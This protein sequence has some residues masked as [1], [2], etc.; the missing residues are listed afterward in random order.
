MGSWRKTLAREI[1]RSSRVAVLGIGNASRGDDAVGVMIARELLARPAGSGARTLV[2]AAE[3]A[4]ENFTG[5]VR[6]FAPDLVLVLDAAPGEEPPGTISL[7]DPRRIADDD[8]STHRIPL[9]RLVSY[10]E[11]TIGSRVRILG[12]E[13]ASLEPGRGISPEASAAV[14]AVAEFLEKILAEKALRSSSAS[15]RKD[16]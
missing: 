5:A 6:A 16:W 11:K 3:E 15:E 4:P 2:L 13:P 7:I 8:L 14:S 9:G 1:G 12:I 10:I